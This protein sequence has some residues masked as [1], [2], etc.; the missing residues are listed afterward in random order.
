MSETGPLRI[1]ND[2]SNVG[3]EISCFLSKCSFCL[4]K[5]CSK[6]VKNAHAYRLENRRIQFTTRVI[7]I[8]IIIIITITWLKVHANLPFKFMGQNEKW[9]AGKKKKTKK[10]SSAA[11]AAPQCHFICHEHRRANNFAPLWNPTVSPF[12]LGMRNKIETRQ[13]ELYTRVK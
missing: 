10:K 2:V 4:Y 11:A 8:K 3:D 7:I 12:L 6:L 5:A 13:K 9:I 1:S